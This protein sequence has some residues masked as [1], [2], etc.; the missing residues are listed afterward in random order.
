MI[1][2]TLTVVFVVMGVENYLEAG[3]FCKSN[4]L[5]YSVEPYLIQSIIRSVSNMSHPGDRNTDAGETCRLYA[6]ESGL[7]GRFSLP[8]GLICHSV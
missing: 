5:I 6:V 4:N 7:R 3:V 8:G 2:V 1:S